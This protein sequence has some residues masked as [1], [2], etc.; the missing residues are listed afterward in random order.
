ME[1]GPKLGSVILIQ[2]LL[3]TKSQ[4]KP[5]GEIHRK[6]ISFIEEVSFHVWCPILWENYDLETMT[7][8]GL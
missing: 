2:Y 8:V 6:I 1:I 4:T 7:Y 3:C 5:N